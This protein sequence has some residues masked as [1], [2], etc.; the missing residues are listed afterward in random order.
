VTD[1]DAHNKAVGEGMVVVDHAQFQTLPVKINTARAYLAQAHG[2][3]SGTIKYNR[4]ALALL[5]ENEY[6]QRGIAAALLGMAYWT[7]GDLE[8]AYRSLASGMADMR[9]TGNLLY[10]I[11]GTYGLADIRLAQGRLHAAIRTYEQSLQ[12]AAEQGER[13]L[14]GA[15][16]LYLRLGEL[17]LERGNLETANQHMLRGEELGKQ[18]ASPHW[19]YRRCLAQ[20]RLKKAQGD[21]DG[22]LALLDEAER[23]YI[24][25]PVPDVHPIAAMK[26][27]IW[28]AQGRLIEALGWVREQGLSIN[29][30]LSFLHEFEH[31][32]LVRLYIAR[33][34]QDQIEHSLHEVI[35]FLA[36]LLKAAEEGGRMGSAI[37]VL[38]LQA[39]AHEAQDDIPLALKPLKRALALAEPE[40]YVRTFIG[41]GAP[42]ARLLS[43]ASK[44]GMSPSY[45]SKLLAG[46]EAGQKEGKGQVGPPAAQPLVDPLSERELEVLKL[47]AEGL[48]N[49]EISKRLFLALST[50]K[51]HNQNIFSKLQVSRRTEAVARA[52]KLGLL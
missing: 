25:T 44:R 50:V 13:V 20:A 48:S 34:G 4:Q 52:Q 7:R 16:D 32:A 23:L 5:P 51:G 12:L 8:D 19:A 47:I 6:L 10:A 2:D 28:I 27:Q 37:E 1:S 38:I 21:L 43:E 9:N 30:E 3:V 45:V 22:A 40:G 46:F 24:R 41:E 49:Y 31:L 18:A 17:Y 11:R 29:D 14:R 15:A 36:R 26:A 42:M 39:L 35:E 33:Y